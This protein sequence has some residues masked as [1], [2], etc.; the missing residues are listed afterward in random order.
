MQKCGQERRDET[1]V[2][3]HTVGFVHF[4]DIAA[5][6]LHQRGRQADQRPHGDTHHRHGRN[7]RFPRGRVEYFE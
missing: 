7:Q 5:V 1:E 6:N 4:F 3:R 2:Q